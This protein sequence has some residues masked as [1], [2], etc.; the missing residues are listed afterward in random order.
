[1][2]IRFVIG[3]KESSF[4]LYNLKYS[5]TDHLIMSIGM[6][7]ELVYIKLTHRI[8]LSG[9]DYRPIFVRV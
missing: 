4:C 9:P 5:S 7:S 3:T 1:M 2:C 8:P 6:S